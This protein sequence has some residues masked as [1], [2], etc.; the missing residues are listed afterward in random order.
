MTES[1]NGAD[2]HVLDII[3]VYFMKQG[4]STFFRSI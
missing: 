2:A 4:F 1:I 3:F